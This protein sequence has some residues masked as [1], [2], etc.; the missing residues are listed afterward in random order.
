MDVE[1]F[2][3]F[4]SCGSCIYFFKSDVTTLDGYCQRY[5]PRPRVAVQSKGPPDDQEFPH[6]YYL[7][8]EWPDTFFDSWCGE[9][10]LDETQLK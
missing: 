2:K 5:A 10:V 3:K 7:D 4:R 9:W 1:R 8:V 6:G